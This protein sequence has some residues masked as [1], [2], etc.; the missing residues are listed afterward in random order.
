MI[1]SPK[2]TLELRNFGHMIATMIKF[3]SREK[4][5]LLTQWTEIMTR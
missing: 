2:E 4:S 3:D 1:T 5:L